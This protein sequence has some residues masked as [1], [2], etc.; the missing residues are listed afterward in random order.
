MAR[1]KL[2]YLRNG[3]YHVRARS[4]N[5]EWF[6]VPIHQLWD[7]FLK[8]FNIIGQE[9]HAHVIAFVLMSNHYHLLI[10]TPEANLGAIMN[11]LQREVSRSVGRISGRINHVFG[12]TYKGTLID[13]EMYLFN[14]YRYLYQNPVEAKLCSRV[15][16]YKYSTLPFVINE[17]SPIALADH[18]AVNRSSIPTD[19]NKRLEWLNIMLSEEQRDLIRKAVRKP[20]CRFPKHYSYKKLVRSLQ[21]LECEA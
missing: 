13:D 15:E 2:P 5:K 19:M 6:Y 10:E 17:R 8:K 18:V 21:S 16:Q 12:G 14:V 4:N 9:Y 11:Y 7:I 1:E 20:K 3:I